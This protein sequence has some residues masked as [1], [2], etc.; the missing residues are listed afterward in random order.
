M[1]QES[2]TRRV[3]AKQPANVLADKAQELLTNEKI[4][5]ALLALM[6]VVIALYQS[7]ILGKA[8]T[9]ITLTLSAI[10][11]FFFATIDIMK[12]GES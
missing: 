8:F 9:F 5:G 11:L 12:G 6:A 1:K 4:A 10:W 3:A 2:L 7:G